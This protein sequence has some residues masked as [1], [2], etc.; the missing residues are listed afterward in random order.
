VDDPTVKK[1]RTRPK[2]LEERVTVLFEPA[3][4]ER[5]R[6]QAERKRLPFSIMV[7]H[8]VEE[9]LQEEERASQEGRP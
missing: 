5:I 4:V 9:R 6:A 7:R 3:V 1:R 2:V 8:W